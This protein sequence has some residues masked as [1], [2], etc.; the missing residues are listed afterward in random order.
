MGLSKNK[1]MVVEPELGELASSQFEAVETEY[2]VNVPEELV[3]FIRRGIPFAADT[4]TK[5]AFG[6][7]AEE[8]IISFFPVTSHN[9]RLIPEALR[10]EFVPFAYDDFGNILMAT[11]QGDDYEIYC[12][13]LEMDND[14]PVEVAK[15]FAD[16]ASNLRPLKPEGK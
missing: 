16:F 11:V 9:C 6:E 14:G 13:D 4:K 7:T 8:I 1:D 12:H 5:Y 10:A 2:G 3:I 15:R